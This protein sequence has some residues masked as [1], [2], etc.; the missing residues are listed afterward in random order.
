MTSRAA[1]LSP[2]RVAPE[3]L[4]VRCFALLMMAAGAWGALVGAFG[5]AAELAL[6]LPLPAYVLWIVSD[7]RARRV[8]GG[9]FAWQLIVSLV[10]CWGLLLFLVWSRRLVGVLQWMAFL[11][12]V[13]IP[14]GLAAGLAHGI[15]QAARGE[16]W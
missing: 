8:A 1:S 6:V 16:R 7:L 15:A 3:A 11:L 2:W 5:H 10:P 4:R 12:A 9:A 13:W 14:A